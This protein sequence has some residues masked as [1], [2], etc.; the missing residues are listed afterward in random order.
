MAKVKT[1][2]MDLRMI[3]WRPLMALKNVQVDVGVEPRH[4]GLELAQE[5]W[6]VARS[7]V[8]RHHQRPLAAGDA[9]TDGVAHVFFPR[10]GV[11]SGFHNYQIH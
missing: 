1:H 3:L 2:E 4:H 5:D 8:Q 11:A 7:T 6:S 10:R 9:T